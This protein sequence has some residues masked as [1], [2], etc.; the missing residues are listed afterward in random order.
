[1]TFSSSWKGVSREQVL[2]VLSALKDLFAEK[3]KWIDWPIAT[4]SSG[5]E[6]EPLDERAE[7]FS[8]MGASFKIATEKYQTPLANFIDCAVREY[9]A[10]LEETSIGKMM[11]YEEE[12]TLICTGLEL[13]KEEE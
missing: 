5:S 13:L 11:T 2:C 8:L 12:F 7:K 3:E 4:D 10:D 6:V 1:M 9:L